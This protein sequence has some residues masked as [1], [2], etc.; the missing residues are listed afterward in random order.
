MVAHGIRLTMDI[1]IVKVFD[2]KVDTST[3]ISTFCSSEEPCSM[4][5]NSEGEPCPSVAEATKFVVIRIG[6]MTLDLM[7]CEKHYKQFVEMKDV[8]M[9]LNKEDVIGEIRKNTAKLTQF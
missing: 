6:K 4:L 7:F 5:P 9:R 3:P 2:L 1:N 8:Y